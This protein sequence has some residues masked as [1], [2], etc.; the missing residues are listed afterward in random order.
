V[1]TVKVGIVGLG[2]G[3]WHL[4]SYNATRGAEVVA[5]CDLN[6]ELLASHGAEFGVRRLFSDYRE[7]LADPEV[8]AV[9][10]CV[11]NSLHRPVALAALSA[12]K[13][14]LCEKPLAN[15]VAEA[16]RI[17]RASRRSRRVFMVGMK[18][19]YLPEAAWIRRLVEKKRL[20]LP[21]HGY[22]HYLRPPGGIPARPT[23]IHNRLSGGGA[24]IDNGV[25]LLDLN[26]YLMGTPK[27]VAAFGATSARLARAGLGFGM[28]PAR[29][30]KLGCDVED[31]GTGMIR[32]AN[33]ATIYLDNAWA[34]F[35]S[36][37][38]MNLRVLG[39]R[40]GATMW[41][42]SVTLASGGKSRDATPDLG[43]KRFRAPTQFEHFVDCVRGKSRPC[44]SAEQG[45]AIMK[46]LEGI[47]RSAR[48]GRAVR[49]A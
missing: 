7:L 30:R 40:G 44:S 26:W 5:L 42:F 36:E 2:I 49:L 20:G 13:H 47:Y 11:P 16:R 10:V 48:S 12:G 46:M 38:V 6:A 1:K 15:S 17:V 34:S 35:V 32:F 29:A 8:D 4:K 27:P 43:K 9:S 41:P 25:H 28:L 18:L 33:G 22:T 31:F 37:G 39:E 45:L 23:F 3:R 24:L 21:Y 14:V 19:R